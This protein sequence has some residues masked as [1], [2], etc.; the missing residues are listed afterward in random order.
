MTEDER[1]HLRDGAA[2]L[3]APLTDD[4]VQQLDRFVELLLSWNHKIN[5]TAVTEPRA[6]VDKHLLDS[7]ALVPLLPAARGARI[8]DVGTGPGLPALVL[9]IARPDLLITAVES[10]HKKVSLVRQVV[11]ELR[12]EVVVEPIRIEALMVP[13][14]YDVAVSRATFEPAEWVE[15]GAALVGEGGLLI[16]MLS[17]HQDVPAAPPGF[18]EEPLVDHRIAEAYRAIARYRRARA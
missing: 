15:R 10:I 8:I 3:G 16:A 13:V 5:L 18:F 7:L 9:A 6:I 17:E 4:Q 11:R 14:P 2:A 12:L 1:A